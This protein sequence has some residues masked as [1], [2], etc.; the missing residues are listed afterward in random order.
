MSSA[1]AS[2]PVLLASDEGQRLLV[3]C[4]LKLRSGSGGGGGGDGGGGDGGGG[5]GEGAGLLYST[6]E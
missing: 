2:A 4:L 6:P 3:E 5:G 1:S